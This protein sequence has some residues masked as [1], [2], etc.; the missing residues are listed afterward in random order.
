MSE[1]EEL[2]EELKQLHNLGGG[3]LGICK[4]VNYRHEQ[5]L[6]K[7]FARWPKSSKNPV[8]PIPG[9]ME[10]YANARLC[11]TMWDRSTEY[12]ALRWELL[13]WLIEE[14]QK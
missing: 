14:L 13:E 12:G 5:K 7:L 1:T 10:A 2:L 8:Y 11:R 9:G 4:C 3:E 6:A